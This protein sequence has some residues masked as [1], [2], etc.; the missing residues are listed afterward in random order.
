MHDTHQALVANAVLR[1]PVSI[2]ITDPQAE[3]D[4]IIFVNDA[5]QK[6]T[7]YARDFAIGR[8]CRFLQ[9][10]MT[11]P[12]QV[13]KIRDG[14]ASGRE[15]QVTL[16]NHKADGTAFRNQLLVTPVHDD[17]GTLSAFFAVQ[18]ELTPLDD[19]LHDIHHEEAL[20]LLRELQ[21]RVKNHLAMVVSMIRMQAR[22]PVTEDSFRAVGRRVEA[23]ALLYE[24]MFATTVGQ[25]PG[26]RIRTGAYL[27]RIAS[28]V[29]TISGDPAIRLSIDCDEIVLPVDRAARLGLLLSELVTNAYEHAFTGRDSGLIDVRFKELSTGTVRLTVTDDGIGLPEG[30]TWPDSA[31]SIRS[32]TLRAK[33]DPGQLDTTG[34][35][36]SA[37][38]GGTIVR[39]L[40]DTRGARL[41]VNSALQGTIVTVDFSTE[42]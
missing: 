24:E 32:E 25:G 39:G 29:S 31:P 10:A 5:F 1:N 14:I 3:D 34:E 4:P 38:V 33:T 22:R 18:R 41:D 21:H 17:D 13:Q 20:D 19:N 7:L 28:V 37:G 6:V 40:T 8:N 36:R 16:T 35:G 12:E 23:L 15:F 42:A 26:E 2:I 9:G 30:S 11:E 27:S